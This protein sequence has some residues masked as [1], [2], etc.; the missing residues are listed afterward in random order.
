MTPIAGS[1]VTMS[2]TFR[3]RRQVLEPEI[4]MR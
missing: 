4:E 3:D 1:A 2:A